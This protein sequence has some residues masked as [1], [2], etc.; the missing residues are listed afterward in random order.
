M[1]FFALVRLSM[2]TTRILSRVLEVSYIA[3]D[4]SATQS[5]SQHGAGVYE[6]IQPYRKIF[7]RSS[8]KKR[9]CLRKLARIDYSLNLSF[10]SHVV[11]I[12]LAGVNFDGPWIASCIISASKRVFDASAVLDRL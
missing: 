5:I 12:G 11:S 3:R 1:S 6:T 10:Y 7:K 9:S 4:R 2:S 8:A